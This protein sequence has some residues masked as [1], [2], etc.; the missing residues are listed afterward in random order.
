V[1]TANDVL[2]VAVSHRST[3]RPDHTTSNDAIIHH[4]KAD[5]GKR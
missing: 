4:P 1:A 5:E 3:N 2:P